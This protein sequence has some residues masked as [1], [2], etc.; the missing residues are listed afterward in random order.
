[1]PRRPALVA[2]RRRQ[3]AR[4]QAEAGKLRM[5][6]VTGPTRSEFVPEVPHFG[7]LGHPDIGWLVYG[8]AVYAPAR[9]PAAVL[10]RLE[11]LGRQA[12][13][14]AEL[15]QALRSRGNSPWGASA[16]DVGARMSKDT[17]QWNRLIALVGKVE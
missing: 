4:Q 8:F 5:L 13:G 2:S 15:Q 10:A 16:T 3:L 9:T 6:A 7:E 1:M 14:S 11:E 17:E 12:V